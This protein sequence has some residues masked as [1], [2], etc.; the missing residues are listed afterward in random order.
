MAEELNKIVDEM[1][2]MAEDLDIDALEPE[3][4]DSPDVGKNPPK[5]EEKSKEPGRIKRFLRKVTTPIRWCG[6]KIKESPAS[7]MIG[8]VAGAGAAIGGKL[9]FDKIHGRWTVVE[10]GEEPELIESGG[11]IS[12]LDS[13]YI[14]TD[15]MPFETN[16]DD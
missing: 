11:E 6:R 3:P 1:N 2:E 7:A 10:I 9:I 15:E 4:V 14:E 5:E 13:G 16:N 12:Q 8:A